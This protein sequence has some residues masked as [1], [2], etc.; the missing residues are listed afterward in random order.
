MVEYAKSRETALKGKRQQ[1]AGEQLYPGLEYTHF[2]QQ[3]GPVTVEALHA[4]FVASLFIPFMVV[5]CHCQ[6]LQHESSF[7]MAPEPP[8]RQGTRSTHGA[9]PGD[10]RSS[11]TGTW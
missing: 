5:Q 1:E 10:R 7:Q 3:L 11:P 9:V 2:L 8:F 4:G 6:T